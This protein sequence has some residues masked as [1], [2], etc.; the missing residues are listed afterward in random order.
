MAEKSISIKGKWVKVPA[1]EM[2]DRTVVVKGR[3]LKTARVLDEEW[4][5]IEIGEPEPY[6]RMLRENSVGR[7]RADIFTFTQKPPNT[8]SKY[9]YPTEPESVAVLRFNSFKE[10]WEGLPQETRKNVRRAQKRGVTVRVMQFDDEMVRGIVELNNESPVRQGRAFSHYGKTFDQVKKDYSSFLDRSDLVCAYCG[11]ELIGLSKV[12]Y[13]EGIAS[14]LQLLVKSSHYDKRPANATLAK[15]VEI[16]DAKQI[17]CITY[18][19]FTYGNK[20]NSPMQEFKSRNGFAEMLIPR[21]YVPLTRWGAFCMKL[22]IHRGLFGILP[23]GVLQLGLQARGRWYRFK[24]IFAK[25]V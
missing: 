21:Y 1:L 23:D 16:C 10:W 24:Q 9:D 22:K 25:P 12:V 14:V 6:L 3:F 5:N 18:G 19:L 13:R 4:S 11:E 8:L 2:N 20:R 15:V 7:V 17:R